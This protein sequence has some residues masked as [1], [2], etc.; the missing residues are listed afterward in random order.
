[1]GVGEGVAG[2]GDGM[3]KM[4]AAATG[5]GRCSTCMSAMEPQIIGSSN[6]S[7]LYSSCSLIGHSNVKLSRDSNLSSTLGA[8]S[9]CSASSMRT[10]RKLGGVMDSSGKTKDGAVM[11]SGE[12]R[13]DGVE[14]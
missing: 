8:R 2:V 5:G 1:M 13:V 12:N 6:C 14:L 3:G 4:G 11:G 10:S 7:W 9:S